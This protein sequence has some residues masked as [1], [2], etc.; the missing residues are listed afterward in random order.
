MM[1]DFN[2]HHV[3][4][5]RGATFCNQRIRTQKELPSRDAFEHFHFFQVQREGKGEQTKKNKKTRAPTRW[6]FVPKSRKI[7]PISNGRRDQRRENP[8]E[9]QYLHPNRS[10]IC[11]TNYP[12]STLILFLQQ[13]YWEDDREIHTRTGKKWIE[14]C[15]EVARADPGDENSEYIGKKESI[16]SWCSQKNEML[17]WQA[18]HQLSFS[19]YIHMREREKE[20]DSTLLEMEGEGLGWNTRISN[21]G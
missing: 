18:F 21:A 13:S 17:F 10:E 9:M 1:S 7:S 16:S 11:I 19:L 6:E 8:T 2:H 12:I 4:R 5:Q 3:S 15:F 14:L 20:N